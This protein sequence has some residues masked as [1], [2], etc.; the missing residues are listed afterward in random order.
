VGGWAIGQSPILGTTITIERLK[1][2][3]YVPMLEIYNFVLKGNHYCLI[4]QN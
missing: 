2:Q 4:Q 3:G 1:K